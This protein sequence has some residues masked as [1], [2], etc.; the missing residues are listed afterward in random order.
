MMW[1]CIPSVTVYRD[2]HIDRLAAYWAEALGGPAVYT[3]MY[4]S[5]TDVVRIHSGN[6]SHD[7]MNK[8][9]ICCV[10]KALADVGLSIDEPLGAL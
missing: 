8:R 2:D 7:E 4:G 10:D 3:T 9:A 6:G 1:S 5:E